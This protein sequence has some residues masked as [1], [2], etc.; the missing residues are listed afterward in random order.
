MLKRSAGLLV[1]SI[2][3]ASASFSQK[4]IKLSALAGK[5]ISTFTGSGTAGNSNYYLNGLPIPY[6]QGTIGNHFGSKWRE[7]FIAGLQLDYSLSENWMI[8][9]STQ[10]ERTGSRLTGD[11]VI[12]PTTSYKTNGKFDS[13]YDFI[14][15]NPQLGRFIIKKNFLL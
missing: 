11:S 15:F 13:Y 14:S 10:Y 1:L 2:F 8:L 9:I 6:T 3:F 12:T 5:G 7:N 4:K